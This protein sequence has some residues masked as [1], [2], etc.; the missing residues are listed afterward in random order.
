MQSV[1]EIPAQFWLHICSHFVTDLFG[2]W[3]HEFFLCSK[4]YLE[5]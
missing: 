2:I 1:F 4:K 5:K 3:L